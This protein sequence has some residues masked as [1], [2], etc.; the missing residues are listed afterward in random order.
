[1][2]DRLFSNLKETLRSLNKFVYSV[3]IILLVL[4]LSSGIYSVSQ[5]EIGVLQR[6]GKVI[7]DRVMPGI[8]FSFPWPIDKVDKIPIKIVKRISID[9]FS[10]NDD[11]D[12]LSREFYNMTGLASY[13]ITGDNNIVNIS[14]G[15]QYSI[16]E[17]IKF[18]FR[19]KDSENILYQIACN[20]IIHCLSS[21]PVDNVLTYGKREIEANIKSMIQERLDKV[22]CGLDITFV[23]L[24]GVSPPGRVQRYFDDVINSKIDK[25]K[26]ISQAESY[27]NEN[28]PKANA[29]ANQMLEKALSYRQKVILTSEGD[30]ERFLNIL[31]GYK[32]AEEVTRG[33][34]YLESIKEILSN[35]DQIYLVSRGDKKAPSK[36]KLFL[37]QE[38]KIDKTMIKK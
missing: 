13:C 18:L 36:I 10:K 11:Y 27:R 32:G 24:K 23:E 37:R 15:L 6:F 35:I 25:N 3:I 31:D 22:D 26:L 19:I 16:S 5:N 4:Y 38:D 28:I 2:D 20:T 30:A 17:P 14:C 1:M 33:R 8:H 12:S 9:D 7:D 21:L 29:L 34:L